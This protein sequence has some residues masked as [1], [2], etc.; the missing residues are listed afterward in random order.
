MV[1][2][3]KPATGYAYAD[4]Y[5]YGT[6][7]ITGSAGP[8]AVMSVA[9]GG[10][11]KASFTYD[12]NGNLT[13]GEGRTIAFDSLDRPITVTMGGATTQFRYAPDGSRYLQR[14]TGAAVSPTAKTVYYVDK[15]Y[16]R[17]AWSNGSVEDALKRHGL[18]FP[19][20]PRE[21]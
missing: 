19:Y 12:P 2:D 8:H 18:P 13:Q 6:S 5:S 4:L 14:T 10:L 1:R 3:T 11:P 16:E 15:D 20:R 21:S 7:R 9:V 17:L